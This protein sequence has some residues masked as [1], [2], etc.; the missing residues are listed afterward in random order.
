MTQLPMNSTIL[1]NFILGRQLFR[2]SSNSTLI[3]RCH[4]LLNFLKNSFTF[5][6]LVDIVGVVIIIL[7]L[8]LVPVFI[9]LA[10]NISSVCIYCLSLVRVNC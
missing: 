7:H 6:T 2:S 10:L 3:E 5:L 4:V 9:W 1:F 8:N